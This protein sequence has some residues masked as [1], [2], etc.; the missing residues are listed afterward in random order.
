[1]W[2][3]C[4][5][6]CSRR[7]KITETWGDH[8]EAEREPNLCTLH[9]RN[10]SRS[11]THRLVR[12]AA[13]Y[14]SRATVQEMGTPEFW[15]R[16]GVLYIN[17]NHTGDDLKSTPHLN[18]PHLNWDNESKDL[19]RNHGWGNIHGVF[20][21][22]QSSQMERMRLQCDRVATATWSITTL[23]SC[24]LDNSGNPLQF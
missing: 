17:P 22:Y 24:R 18:T 12:R 9:S 3:E 2:V 13:S 20:T 19:R 21:E 6:E 10:S 15:R 7:S 8:S 5:R 16:H 14:N 1:M 4:S 11:D 23:L